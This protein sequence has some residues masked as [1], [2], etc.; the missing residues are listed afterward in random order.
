[1]HSTDY[2]YE[3]HLGLINKLVEIVVQKMLFNSAIYISLFKFEINN[4]KKKKYQV[5]FI[6]ST[7]N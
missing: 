5:I 7:Y 4:K 3:A 1:M 6:K 2:I